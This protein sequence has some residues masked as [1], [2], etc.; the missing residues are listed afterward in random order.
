MRRQAVSTARV[1]RRTASSSGEC[2]RGVGSGG[3][4]RRARAR[5]RPRPASAARIVHH[6]VV[7][8]DGLLVGDRRPSAGG[9]RRASGAAGSRGVALGRGVPGHDLRLGPG[10]RDVEQAQRLARVLAAGAARRW[11]G[12]T[13]LGPPTSRQRRPSSSWKSGTPGR[14]RCSGSTGSGRRRWGTAGPCCRGSSPAARPRRRS[15]ADGCARRRPRAC[16]SSTWARSQASSPTMPS[17]SSARHLVQG[18]AD[19]AQVGQGALA[20]D[21]AEHPGGEAL[22]HRRLEDGG[23]SPRGED[24]GQGADPARRA[25]RSRRRRRRRATRRRSRRR[26]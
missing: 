3:G 8:D 6:A 25:G 11:R 10:E 22:D 1:K 23:H 5:A 26:T 21:P 20:A 7:V 2:S 15:R 18:L 19:V 4:R 17:R 12:G 16:S 24:V 14:C 13:A 9:A